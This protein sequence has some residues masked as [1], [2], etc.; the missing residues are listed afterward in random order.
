MRDDALKTN[1]GVLCTGAT[2]SGKS[3][4]TQRLAVSWPRVL[5]VDPMRTVRD[6]PE[7]GRVANLTD[8]KNAIA[9]QW[10]NPNFRIACS[11]S[12]DMEY[13]YLFHALRGLLENN[14]NGQS[15]L[16]VVDEVD[17]WSSPS[18]INESLSHILR[19]GRHRGCS[20]IANC[21]ADVETHRDVRMN[22]QEI[23]LFRQGML[24]TEM[25]RA[26]KG[27]CRIRDVKRLEPGLLTKH[28]DASPLAVEGTH[29][30]AL[31]DTFDEWYPTWVALA[32]SSRTVA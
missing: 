15:M 19:Y 9:K 16:L 11:F 8:A 6:I 26:L 22:A 4:M 31:P 32:E 21:R 30:I 1:Q 18:K 5:Y 24:S 29:F 12:D 2:G 13:R 3:R 7:G 17:L 10:R 28:N 23:L 20:W 27:A 14:D 25:Q